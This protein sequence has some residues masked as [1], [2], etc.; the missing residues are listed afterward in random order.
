MGLSL[1]GF[2]ASVHRQKRGP[3]TPSRR[4]LQF[5]FAVLWCFTGILGLGLW[6]SSRFGSR[7]VVVI[8]QGVYYAYT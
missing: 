6:D 7:A 3:G 8:L 4:V 2:R 5:Q 1:T